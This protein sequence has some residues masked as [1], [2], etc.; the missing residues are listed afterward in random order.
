MC[1][2]IVLA[3]VLLG[4]GNIAEGQVPELPVTINSLRTT[5]VGKGSFVGKVVVY[6]DSLV[7]A[8]DSV[9]I[10]QAS[11]EPP[12]SEYHLDSLT[13][14]LA[15]S[16]EGGRWRVYGQGPAWLVSDSLAER[17][18]FSPGGLR[19]TIARPPDPPLAE[20]WLVVT[21]YQVVAPR[22]VPRSQQSEGACYAHS[23][24]TLFAT[25]RGGMGGAKKAGPE[26][27]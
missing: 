4:G 24:R 18:T 21:F 7:I 20:S 5:F 26:E 13:V 15:A 1:F 9:F 8:F 25:L 10:Q 23:S 11:A 19:F 2:R 14:G 12:V 22:L 17:S 16:E 27:R 3:L 6:P